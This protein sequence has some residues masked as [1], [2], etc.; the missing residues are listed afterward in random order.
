MA[1][2]KM[3]LDAAGTTATVTDATI[4][5]IFGTLLSSDVQLTGA[6]GY[7][8]K[9]LLF[10]SGMAVQNYRRGGGINPFAGV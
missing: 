2:K 10:V 1:S 7:S 3:T 9:A 5:D 8:Q 6:Y 4:S